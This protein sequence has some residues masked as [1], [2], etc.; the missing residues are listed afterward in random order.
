MKTIQ[1]VALPSSSQIT[2]LL[3]E[4]IWSRVL[5]FKNTLVFRHIA[6]HD[7]TF[8]QL[9]TVL[10]VHRPTSLDLHQENKYK[11]KS[12]IRDCSAASSVSSIPQPAGET[13]VVGVVKATLA[14]PQHP[15]SHHHPSSPTLPVPLNARLGTWKQYMQ[16]PASRGTSESARPR[17]IRTLYWMDAEKREKSEFSFD[18][19]LSI[20]II[21]DKAVLRASCIHM[22]PAMTDL[23][24]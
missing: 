22:I 8:R 9:S 5:V 2:L 23:C 19:H 21:G 6:I 14:S 16:G 12:I 10:P 15:C 24:V 20:T 13:H 3:N 7:L 4:N 18:G 11:A 1:R 17:R